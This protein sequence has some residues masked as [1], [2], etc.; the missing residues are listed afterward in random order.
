[1]RRGGE[2]MKILKFIGIGLLVLFVLAV[3]ISLIPGGDKKL[4]EANSNLKDTSNQ[5][6]E[7]IDEKQGLYSK[8][9]PAFT[10]ASLETKSPNPSKDIVT[11]FSKV[12][13]DLNSKCAEKDELKLADYIVFSQ[14]KL[15][16]KNVDLS[17]LE[18]ANGI[19]NSIPESAKDKEAIS[20]AEIATAFVVLTSSK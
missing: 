15:Q 5:L 4:Q 20:C 7:K 8:D 9:S 1:M 19:N 13:T 17:L 11:K 18:I 12:L 3:M 14:K 10:L 16:E 2:N 6:Q